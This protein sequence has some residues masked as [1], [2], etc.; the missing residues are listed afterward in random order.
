M[1]V[2][3]CKLKLRT[4]SAASAPQ[5]LIAPSKGDDERSCSM[6]LP[7]CRSSRAQQ[8]LLYLLPWPLTSG[9]CKEQEATSVL[10]PTARILLIGH[11]WVP[12]GES[13]EGCSEPPKTRP[14]HTQHAQHAP[15]AKLQVLLALSLTFSELC[16]LGLELSERQAECIGSC[17]IL[18]SLAPKRP[19]TGS[20]THTHTHTHTKSL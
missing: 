9:V 11:G 18:G 12:W 2:A 15:A 5:S 1:G 14:C 16:C 4:L 19:P 7:R 3:V 20:N 8:M 6:I 17:W 10:L 13:P